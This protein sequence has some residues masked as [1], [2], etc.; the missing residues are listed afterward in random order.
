MSEAEPTIIA[1]A[2][3]AEITGGDPGPGQRQIVRVLKGQSA[4]LRRGHPWIFSNEIKMDADAKAVTPG[5]CV[6]LVDAGGERLGVASFNPHSLIAARMLSGRTDEKIDGAFFA[7]RFESALRL[8]RERAAFRRMRIQIV[9]M[10]EV[11]VVFQLV[12]ERDPVGEFEPI[13]VVGCR[14]TR[15]E[16]GD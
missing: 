4:R 12:K 10:R 1:P 5:S 3:P 8:Q 7:H 15:E 13:Q 11:G 9:E 16:T 6:D 14:L 2:E